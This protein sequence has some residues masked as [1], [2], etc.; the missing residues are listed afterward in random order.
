MILDVLENCLMTT[1]D[2]TLTISVI[3]EKLSHRYEKIKSNKEEKREK[4]EGL[5]TL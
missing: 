3:N 1:G 2:N 5:G 4:I